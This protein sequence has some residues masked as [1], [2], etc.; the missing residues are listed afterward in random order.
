[1]ANKKLIIDSDLSTE[2]KVLALLAC[3]A[4]E[5][6]AELT[7][8]IKPF[9]LSLTQLQIL[10][11]LSEVPSGNLTVNQIKSVMI[12]ESPNV[13]RALNKLMKRGCI[14][15]ERSETDQRVVYI[16]ITEEGRQLHIDAD[17]ELIK[18]L[19]LPLEEN[20]V[21]QLYNILKKL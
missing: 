18:A 7:R 17:K 4:Q 10:H 21:N 12:D 9:D 8:Q 2:Q 11:I 13:S 15:K 3:I 5:Q 14:R 19:N 1:M 20:E 6:T 16:H